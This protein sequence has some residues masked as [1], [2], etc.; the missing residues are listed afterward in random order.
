MPHKAMQDGTIN[1]DQRTETSPQSP[2]FI[3]EQQFL[4]WESRW[5]T[6]QEVIEHFLNEL[7]KSMAQRHCTEAP[8]L[9]VV[10]E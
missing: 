7:D 2:Y 1:H 3:D 5:E 4:N 9:R 8:T 6:K 10:S